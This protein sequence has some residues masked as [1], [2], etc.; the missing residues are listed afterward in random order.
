MRP[1]LTIGGGLYWTRWDS[2]QKLQ[3]NVSPNFA[4]QPQITSN[5]A[6]DNVY[7]FMI[8]M[9]WKATENWDFRLGYAFD[10]APEPDSTIDYILPDNDRHMY[11][12]GFGY[13]KNN[14][15]L[16]FSYTLMVIIDRE[17]V[18]RPADRILTSKLTDGTAHLIG[19][20]YT[21]KF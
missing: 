4:G 17:I 9:E 16:D 21:Y 13:H 12:L 3:I 20:S 18:A 6:W 14:W 15:A 2:Y 5:K 10:Q 7:R 8:G 11:S 1:D 19:F